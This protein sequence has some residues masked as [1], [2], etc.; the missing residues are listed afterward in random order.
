L[1]DKIAE[2]N[3]KKYGL[4]KEKILKDKDLYEKYVEKDER[5]QKFLMSPIST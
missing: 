1:E 5:L 3:A 2:D 4:T